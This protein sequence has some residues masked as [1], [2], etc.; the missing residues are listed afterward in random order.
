M[1]HPERQARLPAWLAACA[2]KQ[3]AAV[4]N[5]ATWTALLYHNRRDSCD[6]YGARCV[7]LVQHGQS[8]ASLN[9]IQNI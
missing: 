1:R 9:R 7:K 4:R 8:I 6:R 2:T 3:A 5:G